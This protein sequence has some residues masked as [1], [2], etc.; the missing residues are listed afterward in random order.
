MYTPRCWF[1]INLI[2]Y[3][4]VGV[5]CRS[6]QMSVQWMIMSVS[7]MGPIVEPMNLAI[8]DPACKSQPTFW[9]PF[10]NAN[11]WSHGM[12][13]YTHCTALHS[14]N[15]LSFLYSQMI[16]A[17]KLDHGA[18]KPRPNNPTVLSFII[19]ITLI[20]Y[21]MYC[22]VRGPQ[23]SD[24]IYLSALPPIGVKLVF[25][26][27]LGDKRFLVFC[28]RIKY[29]FALNNRTLHSQLARI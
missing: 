26:K 14:C 2:C 22:I 8:R 28:C 21:K 17:G 5:L 24:P 18:I 10:P 15:Y 13:E 23:W 11:D 20:P 25:R 16:C 1:Q 4:Y 27:L 7:K 19:D 6:H 3:R 9:H 29:A 12:G